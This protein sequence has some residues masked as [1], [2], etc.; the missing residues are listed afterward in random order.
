MAGRGDYDKEFEDS[1]E[2]V[3]AELD[4]DIDPEDEDLSPNQRVIL[5]LDEE[6]KM[7]VLR[8]YNAALDKR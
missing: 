6:T 4:F 5:E 1:V 3:V 7:D 8:H 2:Q